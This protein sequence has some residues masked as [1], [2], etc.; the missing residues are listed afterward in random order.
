MSSDGVYQVYDGNE[1]GSLFVTFFQ[2]TDLL[3]P[4]FEVPTLKEYFQDLDFILNVISDGP[5]KS[6]AFRK[7]RYMESKFQLHTLLNE[8][9][10]LAESKVFVTFL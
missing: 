4:K 2:F 3:E 9:T 5:T 8:H 6:F 1:T 7:L 10:E